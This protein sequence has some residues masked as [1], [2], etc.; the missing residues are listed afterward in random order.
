[1][2]SMSGYRH[3]KTV[4]LNTTIIKTISLLYYLPYVMPIIK[5]LTLTLEVMAVIVTLEYIHLLI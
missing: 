5:L 1:M 4:G 3:L 2:G